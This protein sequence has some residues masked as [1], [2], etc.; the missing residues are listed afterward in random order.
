MTTLTTTLTTT[1][2]TRETVAARTSISSPV[3]PRLLEDASRRR[4]VKQQ[5]KRFRRIQFDAY[6][7]PTEVEVVREEYERIR[8]R[9]RALADEDEDSTRTRDESWIVRKN[10]CVLSSFVCACSFFEEEEED[11][12][13]RSEEKKKRATAHETWNHRDCASNPSSGSIFGKRVSELVYNMGKI[14]EMAEFLLR[15]MVEEGEAEDEDE[16]VKE[17][18]E[19]KMSLKTKRKRK[20]FD[21]DTEECV[22]LFNDQYIVKPPHV[23]GVAFS[24][25][26]DGQYETWKTPEKSVALP[27]LSAWV[28]LDDVSE[29]NGTLRFKKNE[30]ERFGPDFDVA[31]IRDEDDDIIATMNAGSIVFFMSDVL[32][33]SGKNM[34]DETRRAWMPQ[35]SLGLPTEH[36]DSK[37]SFRCL[38]TQISR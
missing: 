31:S 22:Y 14:G 1:T 21:A 17:D 18:E 19:K 32:H 5:F 35:Y 15:A 34:S 6:L 37:D 2:T 26:R 33:A 25:H 10:G 28:A 20:G 9:H 7:S 27:Y 24:W 38:R 4:V 3:V 12:C 8:E 13:T 11:S 30:K 16:G 36:E 29:E 23:D